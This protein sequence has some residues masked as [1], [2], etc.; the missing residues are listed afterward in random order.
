MHARS[1]DDHPELWS[2]A[3]GRRCFSD[4][5]M[6]EY[7]SLAEVRC[8]WTVREQSRVPTRHSPQRSENS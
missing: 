2:Y 6:S 5:V 1:F 4:M 8:V 3:S 7:V